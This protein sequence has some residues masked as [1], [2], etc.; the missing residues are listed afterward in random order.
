MIEAAFYSDK[1][2]FCCME[3]FLPSLKSFWLIEAVLQRRV[4][5]IRTWLGAPGMCRPGSQAALKSR[6]ARVSLKRVTW[7]Q[8]TPVGES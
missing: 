5:Y 3:S 2:H 4:H 8:V 6:A 7:Q 1:R